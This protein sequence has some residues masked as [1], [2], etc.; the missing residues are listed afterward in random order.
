VRCASA[1]AFAAVPDQEGGDLALEDFGE[2]RLDALRPGIA[3]V[4]E[5]RARIR[6]RNRGKDLGRDPGR[7]VTC[8]IHATSLALLQG[9]M[10]RLRQA[11]TTPSC[12][13]TSEKCSTHATLAR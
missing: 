7:V 8:E 4:R 10:P 1:S 9:K 2:S 5:R 6:A 12:R 11:W 13:G 3:A